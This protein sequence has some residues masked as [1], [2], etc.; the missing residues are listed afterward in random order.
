MKLVKNPDS[1]DCESRNPVKSIQRSLSLCFPSLYTK[2]TPSIL[3]AACKKKPHKPGVIIVQEDAKNISINKR[4][5]WLQ[6]NISAENILKKVKVIGQEVNSTPNTKGFDFNC[7]VCDIK[8]ETY[9]SYTRHLRYVHKL[10]K[11]P[12]MNTEKKEEQTSAAT[13][14][15]NVPESLERDDKKDKDHVEDKQGS[16]P[17][18]KN[19]LNEYY[20]VDCDYQSIRHRDFIRHTRSLK[21]KSKLRLDKDTGKL[22]KAVSESK[23]LSQ[24]QKKQDQW[25]D[26]ISSLTED[27]DS[28]D[29]VVT[30]P[31]NF[32]LSSSSD[33]ESLATEELFSLF[34]DIDDSIEPIAPAATDT[35]GSDNNDSHCIKFSQISSTSLQCKLDNKYKAKAKD[36]MDLKIDSSY[37]QENSKPFGK[38]THRHIVSRGEKEGV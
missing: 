25:E 10:K 3:P 2:T 4:Y 17:N 22:N 8:F 38:F 7:S 26:F 28:I 12:S 18:T 32:L 27:N 23:R 21:H 19:H 20:C 11:L 37:Y 34:S 14:D 6:T 36:V 15:D 35:A 24:E 5:R 30:T 13:S 31:D 1:T 9:G 33:N 16:H 29:T